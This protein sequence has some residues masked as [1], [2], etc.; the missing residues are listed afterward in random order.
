MS[1]L[2]SAIETISTLVAA[3]YAA[4]RIENAALAR[5][6][7]DTRDF[8]KPI[9]M[10]QAPAPAL[11]V[12]NWTQKDE[13]GMIALFKRVPTAWW[14]DPARWG[15][16]DTFDR[17]NAPSGAHKRTVTAIRGHCERCG[18][19]L[20]YTKTTTL[21]QKCGDYHNDLPEMKLTLIPDP[22][23]KAVT[24]EPDKTIH[25]ARRNLAWEKRAAAVHAG[26]EDNHGSCPG[27]CG[28]PV[29]KRGGMYYCSDSQ[30]KRH[31]EGWK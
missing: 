25:A 2:L 27:E 23:R 26:Y 15:E 10:E 28:M 18:G 7:Y 11:A 5:K 1:V 8:F 22:N 20:R 3:G 14:L 19:E 17:P 21:C 12:P 30:C 31:K 16:P 29:D 4:H 9:P 13:D 24:T 6:G